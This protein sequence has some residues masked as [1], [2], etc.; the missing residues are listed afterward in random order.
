MICAGSCPAISSISI[1]SKAIAIS[2]AASILVPMATAIKTVDPAQNEFL[3]GLEAKTKQANP[4]LRALANRPDVLKNFVP[5]YGAVVGPGSVERRIKV[6]VYLASSYT[7][8]CAF[9]I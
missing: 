1:S 3:A 6:L 8:Q 4:F 9:C 2:Y 5:F 7:N